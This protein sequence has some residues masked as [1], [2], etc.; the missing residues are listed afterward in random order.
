MRAF[1]DKLLARVK[2]DN[3]SVVDSWDIVEFLSIVN[4]DNLVDKDNSTICKQ[5]KQEIK[6]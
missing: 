1:R 4:F 6:S 3:K 5:S 2:E